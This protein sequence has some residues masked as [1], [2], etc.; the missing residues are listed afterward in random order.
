MPSQALRSIAC[1]FDFQY[2]FGDFEEDVPVFYATMRINAVASQL[3]ADIKSVKLLSLTRSTEEADYV[4]TEPDVLA[5]Y[6]QRF[7][8]LADNDLCEE[9]EDKACEAAGFEREEMVGWSF[10]R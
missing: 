2:C 5:D 9:L 3:G 1:S 10:S 6:E 8:V 7:R 4:V